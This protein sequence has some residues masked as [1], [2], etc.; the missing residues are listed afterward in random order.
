MRAQAVAGGLCLAL[1]ARAGTVRV[2]NSEAL[3]RALRAATPG[4]VILLE[5]GEY[6]GHFRAGKLRADADRPTVVGAAD[7]QRPP[8]LR[9]RRQCI[10]LSNVRHLILRDLV[11]ADATINGLNI[12]DGGSFDTPSQ[13]V[14][15]ENLVVRDVGSGG[16]H[17]GI[18]LS[19]VDDFL[20]IGCTVEGWGSGGSAVD[21]VGCHR[22]LIAR[23]RFRHSR[24]RGASGVQAKGGSSQVVLWRCRFAAAG[25]RAVNIGGSTGEDYRRPPG[26]TWEARQVVVVGNT[27]VGSKAPLAFVGCRDCRASYNTIYRPTGW[28]FRILREGRKPHTVLTRENTLRR[29]IV[30]WRWRE[31]AATVNIGPN[32]APRTFRFQ[33]NW[34]YCEDRPRRSRPVLPAEEAEPV[35]GRDPGIR[36]DGIRVQA[37]EAAHHGADA[38]R[39]EEAF[40]AAAAE[41]VPWALR[42]FRD[43]TVET[44][45]GPE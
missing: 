45:P 1:L 18:K 35:T 28:L 6:R 38:P 17:D 40:A 14:V 3:H 5:P 43:R 41:L 33:A 37:T 26:A 23:C 11:L 42:E 30:V 16:N 29:N 4:A 34:W 36:I 12:D 44:E 22:G 20:L 7:P 25:Q 15:L 9:G 32:T 8:V 19:G 21:M 31:V 10:H 39:A 27:F 24:G 2:D 13:H